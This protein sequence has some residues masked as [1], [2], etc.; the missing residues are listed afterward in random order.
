[1]SYNTVNL[2]RRIAEVQD[3][4]LAEVRKGRSY[5]WVYRNII[6]PKFKISRSTFFSYLRE[7]AKLML[8]KYSK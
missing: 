8:K 6:Y 3:I 7:P 4:T 5:T 1:M 2:L